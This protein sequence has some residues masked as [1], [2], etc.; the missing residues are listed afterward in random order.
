MFAVVET[1]GKQYRVKVGDVIKSEKIVADVGSIVDLNKVILIDNNT[2]T[3][4]LS[5]VKVKAEVLEHKKTDKVI[6][7]KKK[8]RHNYRRKRGHRQQVTVMRIKEIVS[9]LNLG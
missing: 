4:N 7:F 9:E 1:G 8:R 6:V 5:N 2:D 3:K